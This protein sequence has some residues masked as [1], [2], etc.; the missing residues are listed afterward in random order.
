[1][2][3]ASELYTTEFATLRG[4]IAYVKRGIR[5]MRKHWDCDGDDNDDSDNADDGD[6][7]ADD[8]W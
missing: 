1:M 5:W 2:R 6:D 4:A 3:V 8:S 7:A